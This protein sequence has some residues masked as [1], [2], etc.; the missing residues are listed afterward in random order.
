[1]KC[2]SLRQ[3]DKI[4]LEGGTEE[5]KEGQ[6]SNTA[7]CDRATVRLS[8]LLVTDLDV[9]RIRTGGSLTKLGKSWKR[10]NNCDSSMFTCVT[11]LRRMAGM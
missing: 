6:I 10:A 8:A 4:G 1:V 11:N 9:E 3:S 5:E 7:L 2:I